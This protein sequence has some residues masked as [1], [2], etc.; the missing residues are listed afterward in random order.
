MRLEPRQ[1]DDGRGGRVSAVVAVPD[2]FT[3]G[4]DPVVI[5]AH[6][7]GNDMTNPLLV[8]VH[9]GI[10]RRGYASVRFN[11]PYKERGGRAPDPAAVIESC[12]RRV[13]AQVRASTLRPARLIIGG[14]SLGGRIASQIA[15]QGETVDALVFLG[16]PLHPAGRPDQLRTAHLPRIT[17]PMLFFAGTRDSLCTLPLLRETLQTL[18]APATLHVIEGADHSF[19]VPKRTGRGGEA[20]YAEIVDATVAWLGALPQRLE[21]KSS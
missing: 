17:V 14:K 2:G 1:F 15:A 20:V 6:G 7:A 9:E 5:L 21:Q 18:T 19:A 10:G 8:A 3:P 4:R 13:V 11:F 12:Y 16:Y